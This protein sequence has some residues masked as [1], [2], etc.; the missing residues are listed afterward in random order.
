MIIMLVVMLSSLAAGD[1]STDDAFDVPSDAGYRTHGF[2]AFDRTN[3]IVVVVVVV[4][5][6]AAA[7]M[8]SSPA[9]TTPATATPAT[10]TPTAAITAVVVECTERELDL[11]SKARTEGAVAVLR[12]LGRRTEGRIEVAVGGVRLL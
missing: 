9:T 7:A 3:G 8:I 10:A 1:G 11:L 5:A 12:R 2:R 4:A 6:A